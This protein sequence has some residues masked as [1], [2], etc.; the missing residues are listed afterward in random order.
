MAD[1]WQEILEAGPFRSLLLADRTEE[2]TSLVGW[3][4]GEVARGDV[5]MFETLLREKASGMWITVV[6]A[7]TAPPDW[8]A[9]LASRGVWVLGREELPPI[10]WDR[11]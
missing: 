10:P 9:A 7:T 8:V 4:E 11:V 2:G 5:M 6:D 1:E 3:A